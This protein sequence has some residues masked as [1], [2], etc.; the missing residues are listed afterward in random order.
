MAP[1]G[2]TNPS[3][4]E[5]PLAERDRA[6]MGIPPLDLGDTPQAIYSRLRD[7]ILSGQLAAG[8]QV[9]IQ[10]VA[11]ELGVSIVP[12][13][14]AIRMLA[15][16]G[17]MELRPNRSPIVTPL[18]LSEILQ[19]N[20]VRLAL[21]PYFLELAVAAHTDESLALCETLI[22][23]DEASTDFDE[24]VDLNRRFHLALLRPSGQARALKVIDDQFET[25]A[26]LAQML[27]MRG[28]RGH[29]HGEHTAILDAVAARQTGKAVDLM[30][31]H[32]SSAAQ[33]IARE[34]DKHGVADL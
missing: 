14:E 31:E 12:V 15:A 24:K 22:K 27:V 33:R 32:I 34:L 5:Q 20:N 11:D 6:Q 10:A 23:E 1:P 4:T 9:K 21:E 28:M 25:I 26:R 2:T 19:I 18:E 3:R 16:E 8:H 29:V 30:R 7:L 17:L 13:R